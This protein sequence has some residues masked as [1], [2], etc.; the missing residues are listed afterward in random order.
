[1]DKV[2]VQKLLDEAL[3][4]MVY[5]V[6]HMGVSKII[7]ANLSEIFKNSC[8]LKDFPSA[9]KARA[10][11]TLASIG[12]FAS[13]A[14]ADAIVNHLKEEDELEDEEEID[15]WVAHFTNAFY[16]NFR[17]DLRVAI[18]KVSGSE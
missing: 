8:M 12:R 3:K 10:D 18:D 15:G 7:S 6:D 17:K 11:V 1:M 5:G 2:D 9:T 13:Y 14:I 4:K 16:I